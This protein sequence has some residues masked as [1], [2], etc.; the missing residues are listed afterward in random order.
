MSVTAAT[1]LSAARRRQSLVAILSRS[2]AG[3]SARTLGK[4]ELPIDPS[5]RLGL[6]DRPRARGPV[7][8]KCATIS[9]AFACRHPAVGQI[10]LKYTTPSLTLVTRPTMD[11]PFTRTSTMSS[12]WTRLFLTACAPPR[13]EPWRFWLPRRSGAALGERAACTTRPGAESSSRCRC[14]IPVRELIRA[15]PQHRRD[16]GALPC[17]QRANRARRRHVGA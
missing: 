5:G 15:Q 1:G 2:L 4:R 10:G 7:F 16:R 3:Y 12:I 8:R 14:S 17:R 11:L 9:R 13:P 6:L